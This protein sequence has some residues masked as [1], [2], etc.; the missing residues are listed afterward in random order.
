[1][2]AVVDPE[3]AD[4]VSVQLAIVALCEGY[5]SLIAS[6]PQLSGFDAGRATALRDLAALIRG[7]GFSAARL[8]DG[9]D[10]ASQMGT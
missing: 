5:A 2:S 6:R 4:A 7:G 1:M 3:P 8:A 10:A 9:T